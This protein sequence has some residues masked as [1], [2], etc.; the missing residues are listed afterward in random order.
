MLTSPPP[1]RVATTF[2]VDIGAFNIDT[3]SFPCFGKNY[4]IKT[5]KIM[6]KQ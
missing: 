3:Y 5:V 2:S 6:L 1:P 4:E